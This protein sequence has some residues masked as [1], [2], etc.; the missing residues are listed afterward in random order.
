MGPLQFLS[1][2]KSAEAMR[3]SAVALWAVLVLDMWA[4]SQS[5]VP[6]P[7]KLIN[8]SWGCLDFVGK[9]PAAARLAA[10][11]AVWSELSD[12]QRADIGDPR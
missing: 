11:A 3:A 10:A 7:R 8:G 12:A 2:D 1:R 4:Q 6:A 9:T 5:G